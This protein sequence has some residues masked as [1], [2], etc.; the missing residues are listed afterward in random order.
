MRKHTALGSFPCSLPTNRFR[1]SV[2]ANLSSEVVYQALLAPSQ[3]NARRSRAPARS[4][5]RDAS[6]HGGRRGRFLAGAGLK[7]S[8]WSTF[9]SLSVW[10]GWR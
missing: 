3:P 6:R 8:G 1:M 2:I 4:S 5:G 10:S 9:C 7:L